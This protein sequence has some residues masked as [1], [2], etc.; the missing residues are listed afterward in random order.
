MSEFLSHNHAHT[1]HLEEYLNFESR[2]EAYAPL[3]QFMEKQDDRENGAGKSIL[4]VGCAAGA[5]LGHLSENESTVGFQKIV[6]VDPDVGALKH[7]PE[8]VEA[9]QGSALDLPIADASFD[10]VILVSV[11]HHLVG[12]D[13]SSCRQFWSRSVSEAIRVCRPGGLVLI[14][15]GIAVRNRLIQKFIFYTTSFLSQRKTGIKH[16]RIEQ[17]EVLAF[18]TA[19][20]VKNILPDGNGIHFVHFSSDHR[21][22]NEF[23]GVLKAIWSSQTCSLTCILRKEYARPREKV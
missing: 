16:L 5:F 10:Y 20:D 12:R 15:E 7:V 9:I 13:I 2:R 18:L 1:H 23:R 6:G 11:L 17:G 3:L 21:P 4:E 8:G 19:S 22:G 14:R